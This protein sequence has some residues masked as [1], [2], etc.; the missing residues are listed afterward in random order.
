MIKTLPKLKSLFD[1]IEF[2]YLLWL[3]KWLQTIFTYNFEFSIIRRFWDVLIFMNSMDHILLI[4]LAILEYN[5][6]FLL[7]FST[8]DDIVINFPHVYAIERD[9]ES[10]S[11]KFFN[12]LFSKIHSKQYLNLLVNGN[13]T[14]LTK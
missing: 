10:N 14:N 1:S 7:R 9:S 2:N 5:Q 13:R 12:F 3:G 8:L 11:D 4:S 6:N